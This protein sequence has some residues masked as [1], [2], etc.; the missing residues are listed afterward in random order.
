[1]QS[2][3]RCYSRPI[4][5]F[6]LADVAPAICALRARATVHANRPAVEAGRALLEA[7]GNF[8]DGVIAYEGGWPGV[9]TFASCE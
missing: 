2:I 3:L 1:M 7:G 8:A 5:W 9:D 6:E 4:D